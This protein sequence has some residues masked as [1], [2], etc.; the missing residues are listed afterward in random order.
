MVNRFERFERRLRRRQRLRHVYRPRLRDRMNPFD[1]FDEEGFKRRFHL[2]KRTVIFVFELI[3]NNLT[4]PIRRGAAIPPMHQLLVVLSFFATGSFQIPVGDNLMVCQATVSNL[5]KK[6]SRAI[7][8]LSR[9]FI[10]YPTHAEASE[11]RR[12]FFKIG[13]FPGQFNNVMPVRN[14]NKHDK[15]SLLLYRSGWCY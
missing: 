1:V 4:S 9:R 10:K 8:N 11:V 14:R 15:I 5:V 3:K 2:A 7:A 13:K 6:V 12:K